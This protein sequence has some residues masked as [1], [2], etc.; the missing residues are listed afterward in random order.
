MKK[1]LYVL[2][3]LV[4]VVVITAAVLKLLGREL[5]IYALTPPGGFEEVPPPPAPDYSDRNSWA[6]LPDKEDW[7]DLV[8]PAGSAKDNQPHALVDVFFIHPTT[9]YSRASWNAPI[10]DERANAVTD[11]GTLQ[12]QA[13]AFNGCCRVYAPRYRQATVA[14]FRRP[15]PHGYKA[16]ELAYGDV[17]RAFAYFIEK[18]NKGR[19]F[20]VASHS[21]G[22][23]HA[24]L[25]TSSK[26]L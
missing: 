12:G 11:W 18:F 2:I 20:L 15:E 4:A 3:G 9:Y 7:A 24:F 21:Q 5:L 22:T 8:P 10:E 6:A 16:L 17:V 14:S 26:G 19:P 23:A 25:S 13:S 1:L